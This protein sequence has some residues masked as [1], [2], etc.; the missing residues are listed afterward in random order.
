[1]HPEFGLIALIFA[2]FLALLQSSLPLVGVRSKRPEL[3]ASA[4]PLSALVFLATLISYYYLTISFMADDFSVAYVANNSNSLLPWYYKFSAVWGAHEGSMLLW[5]LVLVSWTLAV[6][7]FSRGLQK[8]FR[9][10][11]LASQGMLALGFILFL[12]FTS[13]PF[14]R[15]LP[16]SAPEGSDLNPLLQDV[17]LIFHPPMLYMGYVGFSVAFSFALAALICGK[18]DPMWAKWLRPWTNIAWAF[19]TLGIALG[20]WWAYYELGWGGW[21]FWD[22][23][24][25]A[26][27]MPWIVGTALVHSLAVAE[28]RNLFQSWTVLLAILAF[29]L[30]LLGTFLVRSGV[31]TSVHAFASDPERG[32]YILIF[33]FV[34]IGGSLFLYGLRM[35]DLRPTTGFEPL[36]AE[37]MLLVNN[38]LLILFVSVVLLGTL[39]PLLVESLGLQ[40]VSVGPPYFN[41]FLVIIGAPLMLFMGLGQRMRW[42]RDELSRVIKIIPLPLIVSLVL[43]LVS[44]WMLGSFKAGLVGALFLSIWV[45]SHLIEDLRAKYLSG[46]LLKT[47]KSLTWWGMVTA[48]LG[49]AVLAVGIGLSAAL[50][51]SVDV[52]MQAGTKV[53]LAGYEFEFDG[54][55]QE[56][57]PN[58][59]ATIAEVYVWKDG[60]PE[61]QLYPEKRRYLAGGDVLTEAG[62]DAGIGRDLFVSMGEPLESGAWAVRIQVK[63]FIRWTWL[64]AIL[65]SLGALIAILDKRYRRITGPRVSTSEASE[66]NIRAAEA[67]A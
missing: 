27:L 60:F 54:V 21:W 4:G 39:Y 63:P 33:L 25:N 32:L 59:T 20:S 50:T 28:K 18:L 24:E 34:V 44:A 16:F 52:R 10:V 46:G 41:L 66:S 13:N 49:I 5:V 45:V 42:R 56:P 19:L 65:M 31:L 9:A 57:G 61:A 14:E 51:E 30:S 6:A 40:S 15:L 8:D 22:P 64:G 55:Y 62:I 23:V 35:A 29:S 3:I 11:A 48:H 37:A 1:M 26:S 7:V 17:G 36:S 12:L 2:G 47:L 43:A 58:Y 38:L 67:T 53:E